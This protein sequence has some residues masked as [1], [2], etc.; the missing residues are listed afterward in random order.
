VND[1]EF[2]WQ[3]FGGNIKAEGATVWI[4]PLDSAR[5]RVYIAPFGLWLTLD[6]GTFEK[7]EVNTKSGELQLGLSRSNQFT[8]KAVLR[9]EQPAKLGGTGTYHP[10]EK[11]REERGAY[12]VPLTNAITMVTLTTRP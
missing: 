3:A 8:P 1:R 7:I 9:L 4:T 5:M 6:A 10:L 11:L 12:A 2:G